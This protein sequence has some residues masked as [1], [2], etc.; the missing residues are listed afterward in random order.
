V[1]TVVT[2]SDSVIGT[3]ADRPSLLGQRIAGRMRTDKPGLYQRGYSAACAPEAA[4]GSMPIA[5]L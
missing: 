4:S 2:R 5:R 1:T 3:S